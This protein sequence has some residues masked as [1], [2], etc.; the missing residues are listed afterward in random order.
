[1]NMIDPTK[2]SSVADKNYEDFRKKRFL[3]A[4][5]CLLALAAVFVICLGSGREDISATEAL[6]ILWMQLVHT[7]SSAPLADKIIVWEIRLPV[8]IAAVLVG[9]ALSVSG[10]TYQGLFRNPLVSPDILGAAAGAAFGAAGALLCNMDSTAV[11]FFAFAGGFIAV[12]IT[13]LCAAKL[14]RGAAQPLLLVL[15]GLITATLFQSFVELIKY[16]ADPYSTLPAITYWLMGSLAKVTWENIGFFMLPYAA[17]I[18]PIYLLRWRLNALSLGDDEA[19]AL[20]INVKLLRGI[21]IFCATVLTSA[22]VAIAGIVGWVGLIIPH[23]ARFIFGPDNRIVIPMSMILG[24]I[25][26]V[27]VSTVCRSAMTSEIPLGILT[28]IVGAPIFFIILV[29]TRLGRNT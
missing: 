20:G 13:W 10:A 25:F 21:Y 14:S 6:N 11:Q 19:K 2:T 17:G 23:I 22:T 7:E 29:K 5:L 27:A 16:V 24:A 8:L 28:S 15:T 1:M 4:V 18:I 12:M 3:S 9:S 26:M